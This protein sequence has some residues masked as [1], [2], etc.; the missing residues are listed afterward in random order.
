[1]TDMMERLPTELMVEVVGCSDKPTIHSFTIVSPKY[2][3][4]AQPLL[5]R[6]ITIRLTLIKA[7]VVNFTAC[8]NFCGGFYHKSKSPHILVA[9]FATSPNHHKY[10]CRKPPQ[11][12]ITT[13]TVAVFA[14]STNRHKYLW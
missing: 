10:L 5:F 9:V 12:Q 11:V 3:E 4:I 14:T 6:D 7:Y 1:M 13:N 8:G 2:C